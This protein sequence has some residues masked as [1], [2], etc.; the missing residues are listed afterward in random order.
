VLFTPDKKQITRVPHASDLKAAVRLLGASRTKAIRRALMRLIDEM[1]PDK[2]IGA[3]TFNSSQVASQLEPWPYPLAGLYD[4]ALEI[5]GK[6]ATGRQVYDR[7]FLIFGLFVWECIMARK[8]RWVLYDQKADSSGPNREIM[9][10]VYQE[11]IPD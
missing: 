3:R 11:R 7:A 9:G 2:K 10:T 6:D 5:E 4:I 1:P 8:E